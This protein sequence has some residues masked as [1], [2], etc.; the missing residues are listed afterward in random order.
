VQVHYDEGVA[1]YIGP[2]SGTGI[3]RFW[4]VRSSVRGA[5]SPASRP[6]AVLALQE[7]PHMEDQDI[8]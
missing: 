1:I 7:L 2:D 4:S 6:E 8:R 5:A 3:L